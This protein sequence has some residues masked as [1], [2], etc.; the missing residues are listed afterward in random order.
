MVLPTRVL[1]KEKQI[2]IVNINK[3]I[4]LIILQETV[5]NPYINEHK[6]L[7]VDI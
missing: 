1:Q 6:Q 3:F 5:V 7:Y 2:Y 4:Q